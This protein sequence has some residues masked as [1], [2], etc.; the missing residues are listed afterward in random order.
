[1]AFSLLPKI[2][3]LLG[4]WLGLWGG[5]LLGIWGGMLVAVGLAAFGGVLLAQGVM[6]GGAFIGLALV[7][8]GLGF[9]NVP[10]NPPHKALVT[11][12]GRRRQRA[13]GEGYTVIAPYFPL[14]YDIIP[15][16]VEQK[17]HDFTFD[18]LR[19]N[20]HG[21]FQG[22]AS[23]RVKVGVTW[24]PDTRGDRL[25]N[26]VG[27]GNEQGTWNILRDMM[28]EALRQY[29]ALRNWQDLAHAG[30]EITQTL[31]QKLTGQNQPAMAAGGHADI[32]GLGI[33]INRLNVGEIIPEGRTVAGTE[34]AAD[35]EILLQ[36]AVML[37]K[38]YEQAGENR[39]LDECLVEARRLRA[40]QTGGG[41]FMDI[42]GL[43]GMLQGLGQR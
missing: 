18:G 33:V 43:A 24:Q 27:A 38:A 19:C 7:T 22:S 2:G 13:L 41:N 30:G 39:T 9:R 3:L 16:N 14:F 37:K 17:N 23:V 25:F 42:P 36:T 21:Q 5:A 26:Y 4:I 40:T 28:A 20:A 32:L 12:W 8:F 10:A 35:T 11:V 31:L 15:I 34:N 1:M 6:F 29:V